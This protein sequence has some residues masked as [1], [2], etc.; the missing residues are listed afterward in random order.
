MARK[1]RLF[2][3]Q[4]G[5]EAILAAATPKTAKAPGRK[6]K[7]FDEKVWGACCR[8]IVTRGNVEKSRQNAPLLAFLLSTTGK[9]LVEASPRN[10]IW[11]IG[12]RQD[13][14]RAMNPAEWQGANLLGFA[15]IDVRSRVASIKKQKS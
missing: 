4:P 15:M 7:D 11:G 9:V 2:G 13:D 12:P 6:V 8:E 1:A 5:A 10:R 14:P 3:D